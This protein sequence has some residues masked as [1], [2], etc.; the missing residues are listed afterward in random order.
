MI[1]KI[2]ISGTKLPI[3]SILTCLTSLFDD[4]QIVFKLKKKVREYTESEHV[5]FLNSG[6][7]C[8]SAI[9]EAL[10]NK[11]SKTE[12]ILP[13]Y[14]AGSLIVAIQKAGLKPVLCEVSP[15]DF[16]FDSN[17]LDKV[18]CPNTLCLIAVHMFGIAAVDIEKIK[19]KYP[20]IIIIEDACQSMG[21]MI[22]NKP[23][24]NLGHLSFFSLNK[25][26]NLSTFG[27][28]IIV[29]NDISIAE[30]IKAQVIKSKKQSLIMK[31]EI[32]I[33]LIVLSVIV[34]PIVYGLLYP[35]VERF[36]ETSPPDNV[37]VK[38][39]TGLQAHLAY[40][41]FKKLGTVSDKRYENGTRLIA[42]LSSEKQ[43]ILPQIAENSKPAFNRLPIVFRDLKKRQRVELKLKQAGI[44]T[45][46]MYL[47]P[48]HHMFDLGY[49]WGNFPNAVYL[50]GHL[51]TLPCHPLLKQSDIAKII[52]IIK[53]A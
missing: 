46:R 43:L 8:L 24:G 12:V 30:K 18:V 40:S 50:A 53:N 5:F 35:I 23:V 45:S 22:N 13:A 38:E 41:L 49:A 6:L 4:K 2:P 26:K 25:G 37:E 21:T 17:F 33:K 11:A 7:S 16:N 31:I 48:L 47:K 52:K 28:G 14:T 51:L 3:M 39:Y 32:F 27:G 10:K 1:K 36:K 20:D 42:A 29:T 19:S 9:L 34:N 44:E 15:E